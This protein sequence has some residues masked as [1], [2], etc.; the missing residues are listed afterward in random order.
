MRILRNNG[1]KDDTNSQN[2]INWGR[3][4]ELHIC[5][6]KKTFLIC[7]SVSAVAINGVVE[8]GGAYVMISRNLGPAFG[9]AV[10]ILLYLANTA[11]TAM[12]LVGG[13]EI[14]LLYLRPGMTIG[15]R[16]AHTDTGELYQ[17]VHGQCIK[18]MADRKHPGGRRRKFP[19]PFWK[20]FLGMLSNNMRLYA[21]F[22]LI[23]QFT[24]A[25]WGQRA[26]F[27]TITLTPS[28][29][30]RMSKQRY[31][32]LQCFISFFSSFIIIMAIYFPA[33]TCILTGTNMSGNLANPQKSM[34]W[35]TIA[36]Q[37]TTT[38]IYLSMAFVFG[39]TIKPELNRDKNGISLD[40]RMVVAQLAWPTE[41]VVL[42]GSF[43][44]TFGAALQSL[45]SASRLL[46]SIAKDN[47]IPFLKRFAKVTKSNEPFLGLL[48]TTF[49]AELGI[50]MGE[51]DT[52]AA[53]LALFFL[54]GINEWGDGIR[55]LAL[56]TAQY[57]LMQISEK[58]KD[59]KN[60]R[61]QLLIL[62]SMPGSKELFDLRYLNLLN[63]ASQL[64]AGKGLTIVVSLLRENPSNENEVKSAQLI[65]ER[66]EK[67]MKERDLR[68]FA[69]ILLYDEYQIIGS[70]NTLIQSS[71]FGKLRPNTLLLSLPTK[72]VEKEEGSEYRSFTDKLLAGAVNE[73]AL[74]VVKGI[75]EFPKNDV[76]LTGGDLDV[77]CFVQDG[78]LCVLIALLLKRSEVWDN[79]KTRIVAVARPQENS[80]K[81]KKQI[82]NYL[83]KL[84]IDAE[85]LVTNLNDSELS[86][87]EAN[88]ET[89]TKGP[90]EVQGTASSD[91]RM[92]ALDRKKA[93]KMHGAIRL[94]KLILEH[95]RNS[96]LVLFSLP[97]P[98]LFEDEVDDYIHY[99]EVISDNLKKVV[100]V[101]GTGAEVIT[102]KA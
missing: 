92:K 64:K 9:S 53:V 85:I 26:I 93:N 22:V 82:K 1:V 2:V 35:G 56:S 32:A 55:G 43:L 5:L 74:L 76:K 73:M 10:G 31:V 54:I 12:Y 13:I 94:N 83:D 21:T 23:V 52:I 68:G 77:Y 42:I 19:P 84:R 57:S 65:K 96:Q 58:S 49:I 44:S 51:M 99:L 86:I 81:L 69:Q 14:L 75:T 72:Q 17:S 88:D 39:A 89:E 33:V 95:S 40:G 62:Q 6:H 18:G 45:C 79:C 91:E 50:L 98:P 71:G 60:W 28:K 87:N 20:S 38:I 90:K 97:K 61:P 63:F 78:G 47:V 29:T 16:N 3:F 7:I 34:P 8:G 100:F 36:A 59:P 41:W 4:R 15:G 25:F 80:A 70:V 27:I 11:A 46:Q 67:D 101:R 102:S 48:F 24:I 66:M 37:L 30:S